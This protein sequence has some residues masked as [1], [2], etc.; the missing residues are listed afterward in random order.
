M[1]LRIEYEKILRELAKEIVEYMSWAELYHSVNGSSFCTHNDAG[2]FNVMA[3][4][5]LYRSD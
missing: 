3:L 1:C 4:M 2:S 5:L